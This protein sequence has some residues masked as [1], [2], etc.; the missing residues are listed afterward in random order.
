MG[1]DPASRRAI[2]FDGE[3]GICTWLAERA[4]RI[5][6]RGRFD[7]VPYQ[8]LLPETL[9]RFDITLED[10]S[11]RLYALEP[12]PPD[13]GRARRVRGGAIAVNVFLWRCFPWSLLVAV[14][15]LVPALL[16]AEV[17]LYALV[18]KHRA[19]ISR[20]LGLRGCRLR[21]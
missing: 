4:R 16:I 10:C 2:V 5:D 14:V 13:S 1:G 12:W 8:D 3:C 9:G 11:R 15:Y 19:W 20:R 18:A 17:L 7:I 6:R 21:A